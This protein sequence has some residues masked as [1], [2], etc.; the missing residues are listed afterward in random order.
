MAERASAEIAEIEQEP[1][2]IE[3]KITAARRFHRRGQVN[4]AMREYFDAFRLDPED[5]RAHEGAAF[6]HLAEHP[7]L[8]EEV[9]RG[10]LSEQ[11]ESPIAHL[12]LGLALY[13]QDDPNAAVV[14]LE[15]AIALR[16][17]FADA[18]DSLAVVLMQLERHDDALR[19]AQLAR[20]LAP[21]DAQIANNL[22]FSYLNSGDTARAEEAIRAAITIDG[23]DTAYR[24]NL[25]IALGRQGRY[26]EA[27]LEFRSA[28]TEQSAQN[29][30]AYLHFVEGSLD[31]AI[32]HYE[33]ALLAQGDD[34]STVLRNLND[35]L[36]ARAQRDALGVDTEHP[37]PSLSR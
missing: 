34:T 36:E 9:L 29:N 17:D 10:V 8:A 14:S 1:E 33:T 22:G 3:D 30:V 28:G 20:E 18:H 11:P 23:R 37:P 4:R 26:D 5:T 16:P 27:L 24:N 12:G 15:R 6:L 31:A 25:G 32:A 19:H 21:Q 35:A 2:S 7:R 13:A